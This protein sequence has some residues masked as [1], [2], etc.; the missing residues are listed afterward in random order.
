MHYQRFFWLLCVVVFVSRVSAQEESGRGL[1][2]ALTIEQALTEAVQSNLNLLA[3]R[4]NLTIA[5]ASLIT[6][7][8]R[9]NP[10]LSFSGDHM[11]WLGTGFNSRNSAGPPEI[12]W[13]V[14]VPIERGGKREL[15]I[16]T[17]TLGKAAAEARLLESIRSLR[18]EVALAFIDVLQAKAT[19]T[20]ATDNLLT[21]AEVVRINE[22]KVK[23]GAIAPLE[24]TRSQVAMLQFRATVKRSELE[25]RT[26]KTKLQLLLGRKTTTAAFDVVGELRAP[27]RA[28]AEP[29][30][31]LQASAFAARPDVLSLEHAQA[32]SQADLK[33]QV[34]Q[35]QVDF[36]WGVEYRRQE[37]LNGRGNTLGV[38]LSV[39]APIF[40]RNQGE[41]ARALAEGEQ[42]GRQLEALKAQVRVEVHTAYEEFTTAQELVD[43]IEKDLLPP[44]QQAR[45]TVAYTYRAGAS[46]LLEFLDAQRAYNETMQSYLEALA[47]YRRAV[48]KLNAAL[49]KEVIT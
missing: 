16:E 19:L 49:G 32:R 38:F 42:I 9:P 46:S 15:R 18:L 47:S 2:D 22:V 44:A 17:A 24:L 28:I 7:R 33:L 34:A 40:N 23:D 39:P 10:V 36:T 25:L 30:P 45:D 14:D 1:P 29:L 4:V 12:S 5:E 37:G 20:L 35:A 43:S 27:L 21:F 48:M 41:I 11:D 26:A 6:A 8:L 13:R 3:E 31:A